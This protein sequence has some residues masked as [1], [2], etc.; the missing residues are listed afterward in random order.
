VYLDFIKKGTREMTMILTCGCRS[1]DIDNGI[2]CEWD[3]ETRQ[4]KPAIAYGVLCPK[5]YME[6]EAR[7]TEV[8]K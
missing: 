8:E 2:F 1:D 7:P 6:Y 4:G 3:T 5:H